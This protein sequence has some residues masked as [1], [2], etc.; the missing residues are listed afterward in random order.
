MIGKCFGKTTVNRESAAPIT[1]LLAVGD[2]RGI[3]MEAIDDRLEERIADA[4]R[5]LLWN[6]LLGL[7]KTATVALGKLLDSRVI[8][9][10]VIHLRLSIGQLLHA[11]V[12]KHCGFEAQRTFFWS[13]RG[14]TARS[15]ALR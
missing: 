11:S 6:R 12:R 5:A 9:R 10:G 7:V 3:G 4:D 2:Q 13:A 14:D 1:V 15:I 8:G